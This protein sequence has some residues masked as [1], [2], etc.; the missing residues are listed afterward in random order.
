MTVLTKILNCVQ[1][2]VMSK[3]SK[4]AAFVGTSL[5][6]LFVVGS[7]Y[8]QVSLINPGKRLV[9]P[10]TS[11]SAIASL[12]SKFIQL[13]LYGAALIAFVYLIY[14]GV[15]YILSRG[16]K[17]GVEAARKHLISAVI[18]LVIVLM[19]YFVFSVVFKALGITS[20]LDNFKLPTL[21]NVNPATP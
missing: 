7:V 18:G 14:G 9:N 17:A 21:N 4:A 16:D 13:L 6:Y 8:A 5:T 2:N 19:V 12:P 1:N 3:L 15:R 20:P 11:D 10:G